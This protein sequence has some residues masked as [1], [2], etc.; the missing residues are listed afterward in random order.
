MRTLILSLMWIVATNGCNKNDK[1]PKQ[2]PGITTTV[3]ADNLNQPWEILWAPDNSIWFTERSGNIKK[4]DPATKVVT[5]ILSISDVVSNGEGGLLG[6]AMHPDFNNLPFVYIAYNYDASNGYKE[7]IVRYQYNGTTLNNPMILLNNIDA[8]GI[9]NGCRLLIYNNK[10]FI[11]TGDAASDTRAQNTTSLNG[12]VLRINLDGTIP[13]DNPIPGNPLWSY[14]HR[15]AQ[16]LVVVNDI[17]YISEH[18]PSTDDEINIITKGKNY[19]WPNVRGF[20][21]EQSE[22]T[23]CAANNVIEPIKAWTPTIAVCGLDFYNSDL[24]PQWKNSLLL[25]TLKGSRLLQLK[26]SDANTI[27]ETNEFFADEFGRLRDVCIAP[28]GK[29]YVCTGNGANNDKIIEITKK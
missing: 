9:H 12:K 19:G 2:D 18:G 23:F 15:N 25:C 17:M 14:G 13:D 26:L 21:N 24:I 20:C 1:A 4:I 16:G 29:V 3:L 7:K 10:L 22:Q 8:A 28:D 27:T 11:T 5:S 6:M